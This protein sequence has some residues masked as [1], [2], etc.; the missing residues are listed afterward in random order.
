MYA[1]RCALAMTR[2]ER[3]DTHEI[4]FEAAQSYDNP[5]RDVELTATCTRRESGKTIE[6]DGFY[7]GGDTWRLRLLPLEL[8]TWEYRTKSADSGL[9]GHTG[10]LECVPPEKEYLRGPIHVKG[11]HF[12]HAD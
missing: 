2:A 11:F 4:A 12:F 10:T 3:W 8:G 5:F 1:L 7:D 6:V 9:D